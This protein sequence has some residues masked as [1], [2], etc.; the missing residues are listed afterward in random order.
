VGV[1]FSVAVIDLWYL[2]ARGGRIPSDR[3]GH[4]LRYRVDYLDAAG[5]PRRRSFERRSTAREFDAAWRPGAV[6]PL[7]S[8]AAR[9][10]FPEYAARWRA[11]REFTWQIETQRRIPGNLA[12]HLNPAF[13]G[14]VAAITT[15]DVLA[16]MSGRLT[17]AEP[18]PVSSM[19]LYYDLFNTIMNNA[20]TDRI[21]PANPC[22]PIR[23]AAVFRG[24][25]M[26]PRWIPT[27][28]QVLRLF[29]AVPER[30]RAA[31]WLGAGQ[32][33]F[34][35]VEFQFNSLVALKRQQ[36]NIRYPQ[37]GSR[38]QNRRRQ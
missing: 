4:G 10:T 9:I 1:P 7:R 11:A 33:C 31:L 26:A 38:I 35:S 6:P 27:A 22:K 36:C 5:R 24:Q 19:R 21:I 29:D 16:W 13:P 15:T 25:P 34:S 37:R 8:V 3:H 17:A 2:P 30:Y 18:T 12:R 23:L 14:P 32:G 28:E 20:T